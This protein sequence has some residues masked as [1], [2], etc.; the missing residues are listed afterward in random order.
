MS[1]TTAMSAKLGEQQFMQL[2]V[3]Q[4]Q[5]QD[6]LD[7]VTDTQFLSQL[8]QFSTQQGIEQLNSNFSDMLALQQ[9]TQ[10]SSL[11]G[12]TV[13]YQP[14]GGSGGLQAG[15]VDGVAVNQGQLQVLVQGQ[16]VPLSS[17]QSVEAT[18]A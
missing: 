12:K 14:Q 3:T 15:V 2:L 13:L 7:P 6:P 8:S 16:G 17:I 18:A 5:N 10:G 1:P 11:I 4:L 9:L